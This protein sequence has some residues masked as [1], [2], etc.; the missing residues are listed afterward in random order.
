[1]LSLIEKHCRRCNTT[2]LK[3]EFNRQKGTWDG[4]CFEC[5]ACRSKRRKQPHY[6]INE[7]EQNKKWRHRTIHLRREEQFVRNLKRKFQMTPEQYWQM[8]ADQNNGCAICQKAASK[9]GKKLAVDNCHTTNKIR[10][11][12]CN[13]CNTGL[14]LFDDK[15]EVLQAAI[16]YLRS[17]SEG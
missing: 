12:L 8:F 5:K 14:G 4:L 11:L 17:R 10:G 1:M 6:R 7:R 3:E 13:E 9:S 16:E 15:I 2:K